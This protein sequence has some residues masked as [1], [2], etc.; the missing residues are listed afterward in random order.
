M[1]AEAPGRGFHHALLPAACKVKERA[2]S[3]PCLDSQQRQ[4]WQI[5]ASRLTTGELVSTF[6][7]EGEELSCEST[8]HHSIGKQG[9]FHLARQHVEPMKTSDCKRSARQAQTFSVLFQ[10]L[11]PHDG[12]IWL[13]GGTHDGAW[14]DENLIDVRV[15]G[16]HP[17]KAS[18]LSVAA[19]ILPSISIFLVTFGLPS[20]KK[21]IMTF[22]Q[23]NWNQP[24][25]L[26]V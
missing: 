10:C 17:Q 14:L 22:S 26:K 4:A 11:H 1:A 2:P 20:R 16:R 12:I 15:T 3:A 13:D 18:W 24:E 25:T 5:M 23:T 6:H 19:S 8:L 7:G 9:L 21:F